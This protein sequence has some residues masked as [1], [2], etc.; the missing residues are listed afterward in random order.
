MLQ[1]IFKLSEHRTTV[2]REL[3]AG[4]ATFA[5]MAYILAVNPSILMNGL[6][7]DSAIGSDPTTAAFIATKGAL[8]TVTAI[9]AAVST[10]LMALM[11]NYP[12]AL[13]PGMGINA[14][15]AFS[16][17]LGAG[18]RW[19]EALGMVFLNGCIF[20]LLSLTGVREKI[21]KC[22]PYPLKIAITC[23]IGIFIAFIGLKNS[24]II[25]SNPVTF[26]SPGDFTQG[27]VALALG[28]VVLV[29]VLVARRV[30]GAIVIGIV[31]TTLAGLFVPDGHGGQVTRLPE[32]I[33]ALPASPAPVFLKLEFGFMTSTATFFK[34]L[35]LLLTLLL[36]D[37][38]DNIGTLIGVTKRA[39]FLDKNGNLPKAG[40]ALVADSTAAILSS[41]FGTSTVVSYIESASGVEAGGRTGLTAV[42]TAV[43]MLLALFLTP[44]ILIVP[45]AATASALVVVGVFMLQS[46]TEIDMSD[47]RIAAPA[48]LTI[49]GIP[50]T[51]SI[52]EGIGFGLISA[53]LL[54]LAT[55]KPRGFTA[56]G[57]VIAAIF[58]LEFFHIF[59][60]SG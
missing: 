44:L 58:F 28:G 2:S 7:A 39:G 23:G 57:Y 32:S 8:V 53:A 38:F 49:I 56:T 35:P 18:V 48:A 34:I 59:P 45:L 14:F 26:V 12:I 4:L 1:R 43:L 20:L 51:F 33:F 6:G 29:L 24:G 40:R 27:P 37:M 15:F 22:I 55:G 36:V 54:A 13:A 5:A 10:I 19:Q 42:S 9:T 50:L 52:A 16:I 17:C 3:F 41:L 25:V 30:P 21:V 31:G 60:F 46:V 47:F 11:T